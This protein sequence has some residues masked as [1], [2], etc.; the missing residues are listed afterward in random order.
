M[1]TVLEVV[2]MRRPIE[3]NRLLVWGD[4][5][6]KNDLVK[7]KRSRKVLQKHFPLFLA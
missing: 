3:T 2:D 1:Y 4:A 7:V 6:K 5:L